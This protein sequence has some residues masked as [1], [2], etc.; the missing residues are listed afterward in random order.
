MDQLTKY[1]P[2]RL[3]IARWSNALGLRVSAG[4]LAATTATT[5][6]TGMD[7]FHRWATKHGGQAPMTA[8]VIREWKAE[9]ATNGAKPGSVNTWLAGVRAFYSWAVESGYMTDNP[10]EHVRGARR[11]GTTARHKRDVLTD[12]EVV[13][14]LDS[15]TLPR[16]KAIIALFLYEG[17][18]SVEMHRANVGDLR[19]EGGE[20]VLGVHRKGHA[21]ADDIVVI[22]HPEA[23][24][25][26]YDWLAVRGNQAGPMFTSDANRSKGERLSLRAIRWI[27]KTALR[28]VGVNSPRKT[29]HSL[30]HTALTNVLRNGG[31]IQQAQGVG[32]HANPATTG[33]YAHQ[34]S[35][36][37]NAGEKLIDYRRSA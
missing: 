37:E 10:A 8:D 18:R 6:R 7:K 29:T 23:Q 27:I 20:L 21:E 24:S 4:E 14:L 11:S 1:P 2:E 3:L 30:R 13:R 28:K 15:P 25:A 22:A 35:R 32:G 9:L 17:M 36:V 19:T 31:T 16:D 5:Y 12:R 26:L 33:I 34:M